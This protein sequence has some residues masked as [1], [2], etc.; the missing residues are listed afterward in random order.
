[1][2][3]PQSLS[4]S[5]P[6]APSLLAPYAGSLVSAALPIWQKGFFIFLPQGHSIGRGGAG[7]PNREVSCVLCFFLRTTDLPPQG[8]RIPKRYPHE[9][10]G[11]VR[12]SRQSQ[13]VSV[14]V[15]VLHIA[16][17]AANLGSGPPERNPVGDGVSGAWPVAMQEERRSPGA[18]RPWGLQ[19]LSP[20]SR[21]P[22]SQI[23]SEFIDR[24]FTH[25]LSNHSPPLA[26]DHRLPSAEEE[27]VVA[28]DRVVLLAEGMISLKALGAAGKNRHA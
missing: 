25:R 14:V 28:D 21:V 15:Y 10:D 23:I 2:T 24:H 27:L 22:V 18:K 5:H 8:S 20:S 6:Q 16:N 1:M 4:E 19:G 26:R 3:E 12:L 13:L 11:C 9:V 7:G 17:T